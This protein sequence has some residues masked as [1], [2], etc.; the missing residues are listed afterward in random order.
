MIALKTSADERDEDD[1]EEDS[2]EGEEYG[3]EFNGSE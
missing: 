3:R 2:T 1:I